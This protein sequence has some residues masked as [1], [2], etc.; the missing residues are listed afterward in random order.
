MKWQEVRELFPDQFVLVSIIHY[1]EEDNKKIVDEVAPIRT[2]SERDVNK[3][4]FQV[5]PGNVVYHTSNQD[6]VINLRRDPLMRVRRNTNE[7]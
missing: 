5:E 3:E 7:N 2:I 6:F 4:F 1:H